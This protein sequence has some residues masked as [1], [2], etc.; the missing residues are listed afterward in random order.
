MK[1]YIGII[2]LAVSGIT[3][4]ADRQMLTKEQNLPRPGDEIIKQNVQY[5]DPGRSGENVIWN[6]GNLT[7]V[8]KEYSLT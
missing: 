6:F 5:K 8:N 7:P 2:I 3:S 4:A 1:K